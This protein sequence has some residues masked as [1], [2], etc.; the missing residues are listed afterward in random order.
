MKSTFVVS[1]LLVSTLLFSCDKDEEYSKP[2]SPYL[3]FKSIEFVGS[4]EEYYYPDTLIF[5]ISVFD[6]Q[7]DLGLEW[8]ESYYPYHDF[9]YVLDSKGK[10]IDSKVPYIEYVGLPLKQ[11]TT[12]FMARK[13]VV[14]T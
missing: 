5:R 2:I 6:E 1:L 7:G 9:S 3:E 11:P 13:S 8:N 14:E 10:L 12:W 4:D